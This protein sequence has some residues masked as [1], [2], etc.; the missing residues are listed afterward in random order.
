MYIRVASVGRQVT[1]RLSV[2]PN[3]TDIANSNPLDEN[4]YPKKAMEATDETVVG[5]ARR[6]CLTENHPAVQIAIVETKVSVVILLELD[7]DMMRMKSAAVADI[8]RT[9]LL[10][11]ETSSKDASQSRREAITSGSEYGNSSS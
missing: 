5:G 10:T 6:H 4:A 9:I 11:N 7:V 1:T 2:L 3:V 8:M